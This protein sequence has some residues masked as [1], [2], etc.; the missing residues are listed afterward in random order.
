MSG[1]PFIDRT[2]SEV[3]SFKVHWETIETLP[4]ANKWSENTF[5]IHASLASSIQSDLETCAMLLVQSLKT[6]TNQ[7][8]IL[9]TGGVALNSVLNGRIRSECGFE[10]VYVPPAP[11]DEGIAV[12]CAI[13]GLQVYG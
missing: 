3:D 10:Q 5:D 6:H 11:G 4:Y 13:Y 8:N 12:G 1:N 2:Q 7:K 9:L